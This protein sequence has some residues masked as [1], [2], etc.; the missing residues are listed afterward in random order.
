MAYSLHTSA[1]H[2]AVE[3]AVVQRATTEANKARKLY[4]VMGMPWGMLDSYSFKFD[5]CVVA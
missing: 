4:F 1:G 5:N 3:S 2:S